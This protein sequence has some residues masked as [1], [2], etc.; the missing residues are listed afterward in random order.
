MNSNMCSSVP[1]TLSKSQALAVDA[2]VNAEG[3]IAAANV[4]QHRHAIQVKLW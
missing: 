3:Y 4:R 2:D 1:G